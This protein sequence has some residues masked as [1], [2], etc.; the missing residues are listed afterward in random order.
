MKT[1]S[2]FISHPWAKGFHHFAVRV[3]EALRKHGITVWLDEEQ[4]LPGDAIRS[5]IM[6]RLTNQ[7][8]IL[9]FVLSPETLRS[10]NCLDELEIALSAKRSIISLLV[11]ACNAPE[12]LQHSIQI[13]FRDPIFFD[14]AL[15]RLVEGI[16]KSTRMHQVMA[17][18]TNP[19]HDIRVEAALILG[20]LGLEEGLSAISQCL[21]IERDPDVLYW[22]AQALGK[23]V[24]LGGSEGQKAFSL[25]NKLLTN[26]SPR[27]AQG[28]ADALRGLTPILG[29]NG[30]SA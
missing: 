2:C 5:H 1:P 25:L 8:D 12:V 23:F 11:E 24:R 19:N 6:S 28:A 3:A 20:E 22:Y 16:K 17:K 29:D 7:N 15:N 13:D 10:Q 14:A 21:L 4:L 30:P 9:L 18:L 27:V 26:T